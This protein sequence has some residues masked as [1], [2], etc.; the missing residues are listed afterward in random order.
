MAQDIIE[1]WN[2]IDELNDLMSLSHKV[3]YDPRQFVVSN[4]APTKE[5][6]ELSNDELEKQGIQCS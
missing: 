4:P 1:S 5:E 3:L 2:E 6:F